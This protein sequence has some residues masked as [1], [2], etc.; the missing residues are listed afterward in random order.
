MQQLRIVV[1]AS[2]TIQGEE[3]ASIC[4]I[5]LYIAIFYIYAL[6]NFRASPSEFVIP[7]AKYAKALYHTRVSLGM[8]FRMLFETEES[9]VRR[10]V[11]LF[12]TFSSKREKKE[13]CPCNVYFLYIHLHANLMSHLNAAV[14]GE[15]NR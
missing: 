3:S 11:W 4:G 5:Q 8:R 15:L 12:P 1:S 9:S 6:L 13:C 14:A 7:L 2:F 10:Y